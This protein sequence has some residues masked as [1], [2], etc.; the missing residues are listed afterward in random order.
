[1]QPV[2]TLLIS[3]P[4]I[5]TAEFRAVSDTNT[6]CTSDPVVRKPVK[7]AFRTQLPY[8]ANFNSLNLYGYFPDRREGHV[9]GPD[10]L[11]RADRAGRP[12]RIGRGKPGKRAAD[13]LHRRPARNSG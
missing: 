9:A 11:P 3:M 13:V 2:R 8:Y 6:H 1:M 12:P 7:R 10:R 5:P 4:L